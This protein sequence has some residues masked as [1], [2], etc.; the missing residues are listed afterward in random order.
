MTLRGIDRRC[1][2]RLKK[3]RNDAEEVDEAKVAYENRLHAHEQQLLVEHYNYEKL[4]QK[5]YAEMTKNQEM[6]VNTGE[7]RVKP[8]V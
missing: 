2:L 4:H 8:S 6:M 7:N 3:R 1:G 5:T